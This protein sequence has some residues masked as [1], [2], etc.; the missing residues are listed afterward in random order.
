MKNIIL[1][2]STGSI[3]E[4][5]LDIVSRFPERFKII[6]MAAGYNLDLFEKQIRRFSPSTVSVADAK[7]AK[8]LKERCFDLKLDILEGEKG[9]LQVA[10][11]PDGELVVSAIVGARGL[12]PTL[13]AIRA[14]KDIALANKESMVTAG[15]LVCQEAQKTGV[16]ILPVDSEHSAVFQALSGN[17][18]KNVRKII[19]TASGGP[20][21]NL[22][23]KEK[24]SVT[25][26]AAVKHP[27]W[28]M[29]KKISIDSSTLMN[30][31][32]EVIEAKWLFDL[33]VEEI[34]VVI[35]PQSIVHSMV[36]YIDGSVIA[37]MGVPD[38]RGPISYALGYPER[39]PLNLQPLNL[40]SSE[41]LT[42]SVPNHQDFPC[43]AFGYDAL[44]AGGTMPAV[45]NAANEEAVSAFLSHKI[46]FLEI[47]EVIKKT[48]DA[49]HSGSIKT[50][51]DV[52][53][54][55]GWARKE[56][57]RLIDMLQGKK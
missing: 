57:A 6:A 51:D 3:G 36:E 18:R 39:L 29:G 7:S 2:G 42:F 14:G 1:L 27:K 11:S 35:H 45:L 4:S 10:T 25:P 37:Q 54:A 31:G 49:H 13:A 5:T 44:F 32:L 52:L 17:Q 34:E 20:F 30:K 9:L 53:Y 26:E 22:S 23:R 19:L 28:L 12:L 55:D 48:M 21:L 50:L 16:R 40:T 38:M 24:E 41:S 43:L 56:A 46:R 15:E 33:K 47:E 8:I